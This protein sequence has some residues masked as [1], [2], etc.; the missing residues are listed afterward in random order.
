MCSKLSK[1]IGVIYKLKNFLPE[2]PLRS[3]Y[4][5]LVL[6]YLNYCV[7]AW[8]AVPFSSI[9]PLYLLQK[10]L[11]R[12]VSHADYLAHTRPLFY[13]NLT[14]NIMDLYKFSCLKLTYR[15]L[16][17]D[18]KSCTFFK[19]VISDN[20]TNV[21]YPTRNDQH[22]TPF[23]SSNRSRQSLLY[24]GLRLWNILPRDLKSVESF[25]SFKS[26]LLKYFLISYSD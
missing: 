15:F 12:L 5:S 24:N 13:D 20:Q 2:K 3:L 26:K 22:R 1:T 16:N 14:L 23:F 21:R 10:K 7:S 9:S 8:G 19:E 18:L 25:N 17:L 6:P 4:N 11:I